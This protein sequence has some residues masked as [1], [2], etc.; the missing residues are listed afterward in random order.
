MAGGHL[1]PPPPTPIL[2]P[3]E[4]KRQFQEHADFATYS[5]AIKKYLNGGITK[6]EFHA[7]LSKV[8]PTKEKST[9]FRK[10]L[11]VCVC[12]RC[13]SC[14]RCSLAFGLFC[15]FGLMRPFSRLLPSLVWSSCMSSGATQ[16][17]DSEYL[18]VS[19]FRVRCTEKRR[20]WSVRLWRQLQVPKSARL[21][22][23]FRLQEAYAAH[24]YAA[25]TWRYY[26]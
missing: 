19:V 4:V 13:P 9:Y 14:R 18:E 24:C 1:Q 11:C 12:A 5:K 17:V 7:E 21:E 10:L 8:L 2:R 15:N 16:L 26:G 25:S 6:T 23:P 20:A 3:T 22:R